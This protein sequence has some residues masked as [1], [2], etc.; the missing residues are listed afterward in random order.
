M[1]NQDYQAIML[2]YREEVEYQQEKIKLRKMEMLM[3]GSPKH[4][5]LIWRKH[6]PDSEQLCHHS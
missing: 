6:C 5:V 4:S 3:L 1:S 2:F